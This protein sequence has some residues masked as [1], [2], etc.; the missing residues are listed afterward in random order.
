MPDPI[1]P[2]VHPTY[3][4]IR[5]RL[6]RSESGEISHA[7][8]CVIIGRLANLFLFQSHK[9]LRAPDGCAMPSYVA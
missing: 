6:G 9:A 2:C 3:L 5:D 1:I 4:D 7:D 8:I